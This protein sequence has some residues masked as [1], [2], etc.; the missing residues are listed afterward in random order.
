[1][2][3]YPCD[4]NQLTY[5]LP[6]QQFPGHINTKIITNSSTNRTTQIPRAIDDRRRK[7]IHDDER[8]EDVLY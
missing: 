8:F 5:V 2:S 7:K 6:T 1:M 3:G 4:A